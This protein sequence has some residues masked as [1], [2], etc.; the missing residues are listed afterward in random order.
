MSIYAAAMLGHLDV[1]KAIVAA[2]PGIQKTHGPHS[3]TL[4]AHARAGGPD[5][6]PVVK[7]LEAVGDADVP[8]PTQPLGKSDRDKLVG[9]YRYGAS[10]SEVFHV[11]VTNERLGITRVGG[12]RRPLSH[13]G[14][15]VFSP[16]GAPAVRI[17]FVPGQLTI[18][19]PEVFVVAKREP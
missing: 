19:D 5:S 15:L 4:L 6:L 13:R 10:A 16:S 17:A 8:T 9:E 3:I 1:V 14:N 18:A 2:S 11:D 12:T 7:Y